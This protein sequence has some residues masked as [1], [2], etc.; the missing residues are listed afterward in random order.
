VSD[1]ARPVL[2]EIVA[3]APTEFFHCHHCEV[4]W[5]ASGAMRGVRAEQRAS[6]LPGDL[7]ATYQELSNWARDLALEHGQRLR[8]GV[9]DAVSPQGLWKM[10]RYRLGALPAVI[11][12]GA[13]CSDLSQAQALVE[14]RVARS[15]GLSATIASAG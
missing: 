7:S 14:A 12:D 2:V 15:R 5:Q 6:S 13:V 3:F 11:V 4:I 1:S 9:V 10:M 8:L